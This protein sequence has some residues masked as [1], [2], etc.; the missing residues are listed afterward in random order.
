MFLTLGPLSERVG[1]PGR[2]PGP[3]PSQVATRN[4]RRVPA[5]A[6]AR[7]AEP[8]VSPGAAQVLDYYVR[9]RRSPWV[10]SALSVVLPTVIGIGALAL[11]RRLFKAGSAWTS[12]G[13]WARKLAAACGSAIG[14]H[15]LTD[16]AG[17]LR[18]AGS[19]VALTVVCAV[20]I[21]FG[22]LSA[23]RVYRVHVSGRGGRLAGGA[24]V[25]ALV[26]WV[27]TTRG[28][29]GF[30][31]RLL[32]PILAGFSCAVSGGGSGISDVMAALAEFG[33]GGAAAAL[34]AVGAGVAFL[35]WRF[36]TDDINGNWSDSYV[37][38]EKL[39]ALMSLFFIAAILL[40]V[41]NLFLT[42]LIG[43]SGALVAELKA[44]DGGPSAD[45]LKAY[46][47]SLGN[48]FGG[49]SSLVLLAMFLPA[50]LVLID[51]IEI[52]GRTHAA[53]DMKSDN[54]P[55]YRVTGALS[56][57]LPP[58]PS[59]LSAQMHPDS[60]RNPTVPPYRVAGWK[61]VKDW[62]DKHG[63]AMSVPDVLASFVAVA[64][65]LLANSVVDVAKLVL[66][67]P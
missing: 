2:A 40:V 55:I 42:S 24:A 31:A 4:A 25:A 64:A 53:Y 34:F 5:A 10:Y 22:I 67:G 39:N 26:L 11:A 50:F 52:A 23:R 45:A 13:D 65:P 3:S 51:D 33:G 29:G 17:R 36:E 56:V 43:A 28:F 18:L 60:Q 8:G 54:S 6:P 35:A 27:A 58:S 57:T 49:V 37:L 66:A 63:L 44:P 62:K 59:Q 15:A 14:D 7:P 41:A 47:S 46:A 1:V 9:T 19:L 48:Y 38:R 12:G 61:V 21:A 16:Q 30:C 20:A 32:A